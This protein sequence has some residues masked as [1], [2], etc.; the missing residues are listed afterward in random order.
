MNTNTIESEKKEPRRPSCKEAS[1]QAQEDRANK[2]A[3]VVTMMQRAKGATLAEI[4]DVTE[5]QAHTVGSQGFWYGDGAGLASD[6]P[7][8]E[9]SRPA[10]VLRNAGG[11][12][13]MHRLA[14][15]ILMQVAKKIGNS[16]VK[17]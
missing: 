12:G 8:C 17:M 4:M 2:K 14:A 16:R 5:W 3:E 11:A 7:V 13:P 10:D 9:L 1:Q 15:E 6:L